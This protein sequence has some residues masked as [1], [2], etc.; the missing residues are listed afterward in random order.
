MSEESKPLTVTAVLLEAKEELIWAEGHW[1]A[2]YSTITKRIDALL[3]SLSAAPEALRKLD[4]KAQIGATVFGVGVSWATVIGRAER[5]W[6]YF[7]G[8]KNPRSSSIE[9]ETWN[10]AMERAAE[11]CEAQEPAAPTAIWTAACKC[12]AADIRAS[13]LP[14]PVPQPGMEFPPRNETTPSPLAFNQQGEKK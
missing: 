8:L 2:D 12:C 5:E 9:E 7:H 6:D 13:K 14:L 4:K 11:I 3:E 10:A 1:G